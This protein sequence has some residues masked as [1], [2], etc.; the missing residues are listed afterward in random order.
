MHFS[1]HLT[2]YFQTNGRAGCGFE[3]GTTWSGGAF[4]DGPNANPIPDMGGPRGHQ[5]STPSS[6]PDDYVKEDGVLQ[7]SSSSLRPPYRSRAV[8]YLELHLIAAHCRQKV[9]EPQ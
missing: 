4:G 2:E 8:P 3:S 7:H 5:R 9:V 1:A 6:N